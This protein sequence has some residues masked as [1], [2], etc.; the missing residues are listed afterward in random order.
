MRGIQSIPLKVLRDWQ[1]RLEVYE[2]DYI[3]IPK[4]I[5]RKEL[6]RRGKK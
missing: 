3:K 5:I 6:K 2:G 4:T 1:W